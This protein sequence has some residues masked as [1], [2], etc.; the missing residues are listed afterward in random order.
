MLRW[1]LWPSPRG[2]GFEVAWIEGILRVERRLLGSLLKA[3][4]EGFHV[5]RPH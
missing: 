3:A 5:V 4:D 1:R 2:R